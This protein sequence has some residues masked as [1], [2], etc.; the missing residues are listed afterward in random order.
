MPYKRI[1]WNGRRRECQHQPKAAPIDR[2]RQMLAD[3]DFTR[4]PDTKFDL[5]WSMGGGGV[6]FS[7]RMCTK[8]K[9]HDLYTMGKANLVK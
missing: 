7:L 8:K 9:V 1:I 2:W 5:D 3:D 6:F 4:Y